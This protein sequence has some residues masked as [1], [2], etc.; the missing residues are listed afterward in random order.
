MGEFARS[1]RDLEV[2]Q[3]SLTLALE[4]HEFVSAATDLG[5]ISAGNRI[6]VDTKIKLVRKPSELILIVVDELAI[7]T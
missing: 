5:S 7:P 2:Y 3:E 1:F 6:I 4:V